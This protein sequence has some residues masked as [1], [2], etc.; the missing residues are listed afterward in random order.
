LSN[1]ADLLQVT[2]PHY[3]HLPTSFKLLRCEPNRKNAKFER[4]RLVATTTQRHSTKPLGS[5]SLLRET[6]HEFGYKR[7]RPIASRGLRES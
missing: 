6:T 7:H 1:S 5:G 4:K 3:A 2:N